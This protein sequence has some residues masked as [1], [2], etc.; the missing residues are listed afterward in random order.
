MVSGQV[1]QI[2]LYLFW[3]LGGS[4]AQT[5]GRWTQ[6]WALQP[7]PPGLGA[8]A[9]PEPRPGLLPLHAV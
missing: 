5:T 3:G 9:T 8:G 1:K 6:I 2:L 7:S 4:G